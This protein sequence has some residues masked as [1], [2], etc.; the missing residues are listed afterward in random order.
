MNRTHIAPRFPQS[1]SDKAAHAAASYV[2]SAA[3]TDSDPNADELL[4]RA[5]EARQHRLETEAAYLERE[6]QLGRRVAQEIAQVA[7]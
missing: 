2:R 4:K 6:Q 7:A 3:P 5:R 1:S